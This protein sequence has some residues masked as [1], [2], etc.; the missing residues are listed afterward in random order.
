MTTV[1]AQ[2]ADEQASFPDPEK[3]ITMIVP[4]GAGGGT[5]TFARALAI[6]S[7][8]KVIVF[9]HSFTQSDWAQVTENYDKETPVLIVATGFTRGFLDNEYLRYLKERGLVHKPASLVLA[10][11]KGT[12]VQYE[13]Q[14]FAAVIKQKPFS[15][16]THMNVNYDEIPFYDVQVFGGNCLCLDN[17]EPPTEYIEDLKYEIKKD[18]TKSIAKK[19]NFLERINALEMK[20]EDTLLT[21]KAPTSLEAKLIADKIDDCV[22]IIN[23]AAENGVVPNMFRYGYY[24]IEQM[25]ESTE[26]HD[27][28]SLHDKINT[29]IMYAIEGLFRD[30]WRSKYGETEE[31]SLEEHID[32]FY[33][34]WTSFDII[35]DEFCEPSKFCTSSQYDIEVIVAAISIVKYL[36]TSKALIFDASLL[37]QNAERPLLPV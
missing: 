24:R 37:R 17:V 29:Q 5:D 6:P 9:D 27:T 8:M 11:M 15:L 26:E 28:E 23:S 3:T 2:A 20:A 35:D 30:I 12:F 13:I 36:I 1:F 25:R 21:V 18:L 34:N 19:N 33:T 22:S 7:K 10:E 14:D 4:Q 31:L 16:N 32:A